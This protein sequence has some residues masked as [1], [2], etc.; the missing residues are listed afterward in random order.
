MAQAERR[1][2]VT[3]DGDLVKGSGRLSLASSGALSDSAVTWAS[4]TETPDGR[5]SPEELLAGSHASCYAMAFAATLGRTGTPP[6]R[7]HVDAVCSLDRRPEGGF[8]VTAM[9]LTVTGR[10]SGLDQAGFEAAARTA[11]QGCPISNALRGNV[12][13]TV[14]AT[15]DQA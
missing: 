15:L 12:E 13:I 10:V 4:R 7:L 3:W 5:T 9:A 1:A 2:D 6:E 14:T 8:K 11:E